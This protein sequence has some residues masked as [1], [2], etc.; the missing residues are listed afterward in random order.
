[1][2]NLRFIFTIIALCAITGCS[3]EKEKEEEPDGGFNGAVWPMLFCDATI[4]PYGIYIPLNEEATIYCVTLH[5]HDN[6]PLLET[7]FSSVTCYDY[8]S[9]NKT[10]HS[11]PQP[12]EYPLTIQH[13]WVEIVQDSP[14]TYTIKVKPHDYKST[15]DITILPQQTIGAYYGSIS[16]DYGWQPV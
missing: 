10:E 7:Y 3:K 15:A 1:M 5:Y 9:G 8:D 13:E 12:E 4:G 11:C 16:I 2:K 14:Y 6:Y